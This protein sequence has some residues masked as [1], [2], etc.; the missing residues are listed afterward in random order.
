[1]REGGSAGKATAEWN[2]LTKDWPVVQGRQQLG[3]ELLSQRWSEGC[4]SE[5]ALA[6]GAAKNQLIKRH[7]RLG[8]A[9]IWKES[10]L[11]FYI[12]FF[13]LF[14]PPLAVCLSVSFVFFVL[15][16]DSGAGGLELASVRDLRVISWNASP[17]R[18]SR[19]KKKSWNFLTFWTILLF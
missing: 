2:L 10:F 3:G 11:R 5:A 17:E 9:A 6:D 15:C 14:P 19:G 12:I 13:S 16:R 7:C 18:A 8:S 1:M 4:T